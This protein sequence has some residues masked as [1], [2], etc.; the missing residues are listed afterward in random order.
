[1]KRKVFGTAFAFVPF[2]SLGSMPTLAAVCNNV[3]F[4][5][6]NTDPGN[7]LRITRVEYKDNSSGNPSATHTEDIPAIICVKGNQC[8]STPQ[9]LGSVFEPRENHD[10]YDIKYYYA[11]RK[12]TGW[13]TPTWSSPATPYDMRC[14]DGRSYG[15][16][17]IP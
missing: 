7:D 11:Y 5:A 13:G 12:G 2:F 15:P 14:T 9:N 6:Q 10:L 4:Y 8:V 3:S 1:M 16:Y 17:N